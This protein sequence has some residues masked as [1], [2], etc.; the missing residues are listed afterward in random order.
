MFI[1]KIYKEE[2]PYI[3]HESMGIRY[4]NRM[5]IDEEDQFEIAAVHTLLEND[6]EKSDDHDIWFEETIFQEKMNTAVQAAKNL[7]KLRNEEQK[8]GSNNFYLSF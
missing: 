4:I 5:A 3:Q 2:V 7:D 1:E 8:E 6:L